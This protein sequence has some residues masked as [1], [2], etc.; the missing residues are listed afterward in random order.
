MPTPEENPVPTDIRSTYLEAARSAVE[1]VQQ[2]VVAQR[3]QQPSALTG[4]TVGGLAAH[5]ALQLFLAANVLAVV[6]PA[7]EPI[8]L[9]E[10]YARVRWI[11]SSLDSEANV[12]IRQAG[13][14]AAGPGA[15]ALADRAQ[16]TLTELR[17]TIPD[18]PSGRVVF[19]SWGPW[20]LT[21]D[22]FLTT[23]TMEIAVHSDDLAVS[24]DLPTPPLP[25]EATD[26]VLQLLTQL[27]VRRHGPT[28]VMRALSRAERAPESIAAF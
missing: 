3:W 6:E 9:L 8:P 16:A 15:A 14:D 28:A 13:E 23:R 10:H 18:Q 5:L 12:S 22:T 17:T 21:L 19:I 27:A 7:E 20:A 24:V 4:F 1:L 26:T 2:P 11:G 25:V